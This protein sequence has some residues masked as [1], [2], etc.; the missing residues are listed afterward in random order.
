MGGCIVKLLLLAGTC[1]FWIGLVASLN[2]IDFSTGTKAVQSIGNPIVM[3]IGLLIFGGML[4]MSI[5]PQKQRR[6]PARA[7]RQ[8]G[9]QE[10]D[11]RDEYPWQPEGPKW[12]APATHRTASESYTGT[13]RLD[14]AIP[15]DVSHR[16][17]EPA[18][19][20]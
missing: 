8:A 17:S 12:G 4:L 15:V 18:R 3:V 2:W 19:R 9:Q 14:K 7:E 13:G 5:V 10:H 20:R 11:P 16:V 6:G 1:F